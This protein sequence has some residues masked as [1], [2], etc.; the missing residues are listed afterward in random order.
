MQTPVK[1]HLSVIGCAAGLLS[2]LWGCAS[3]G[4]PSGGRRDEDPPRF[5]SA[6]P[7]PGSVNV[8]P[9]DISIE[10]NELVNVKDAYQ[11]VVLSPRESPHRVS[12]QGEDVL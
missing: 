1:K 9:S 8:D 10:F 11:N 5:I 4:N 7:A 3:I 12:A 2:L 6:R